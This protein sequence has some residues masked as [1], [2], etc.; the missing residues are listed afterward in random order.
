MALSSS[1]RPRSKHPCGSSRCA[2]APPHPPPD[3]TLSA[4]SLGVRLRREQLR[5]FA[6]D[7][8]IALQIDELP[9]SLHQGIYD[10]ARAIKEEAEKATALQVQEAAAAGD[11]AGSRVWLKTQKKG[12]VEAPPPPEEDW[13]GL[14][15]AFQ[16]LVDSPTIRGAAASLCGADCAIAPAAA[17]PQPLSIVDRSQ[18]Q[19]WHKVPPPL[20]PLPPVLDEASL[21]TWLLHRT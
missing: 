20:S 19:Q 13:S 2:A 18:D 12:K 14:G 21:L 11:A 8:F 5:Q 17:A 7:G 3:P 9:A 1:R 10:T 6:R 4:D 16:A 15:P